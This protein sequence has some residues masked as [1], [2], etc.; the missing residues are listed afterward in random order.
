MRGRLH[1]DLTG[2]PF[3]ELVAKEYVGTNKHRNSIWKCV[4]SC[5]NVVEVTAGNLRRGQTK[6]CGHL[7]KQAVRKA[8]IT[9]GMTNSFEYSVW[10]NM[11]N[12]CRNKNVP[13]YKD[14]GGRG[15]TVCARWLK[16]ETFLFDMGRAPGPGYSIERKRVNEGYN[17]GNCTWLLLPD[18]A[19]NRRSSRMITFRGVT[20]SAKDWGKRLGFDGG[21]LRA[22]LDVQGWSIERALTTPLRGKAKAA[23]IRA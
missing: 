8:S 23:P 22:R 5:G 21:T 15:I 11:L 6:S 17:P 18:Q 9:H 2:Q 13:A 3:G 12:R 7:Q 10:Q 16:F 4:C 19:N 1:D 20:L 14:Y